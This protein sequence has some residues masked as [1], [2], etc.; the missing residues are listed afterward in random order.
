MTVRTSAGAGSF[1]AREPQPSGFADRD[2]AAVGGVDAGT[3]ID[4]DSRMIGVGVAFAGEGLEVPVA[5]LVAVIDD[6]GFFRL[7]FA[8]LPAALT[9]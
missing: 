6:P 5:E 4:R 7:A 8:G 3:D 2:A 1:S 9:Y